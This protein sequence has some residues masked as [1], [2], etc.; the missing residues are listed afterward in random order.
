MT[1]EKQRRRFYLEVDDGFCI[2]TLLYKSK[3]W[4][5]EREWRLII[6][7]TK[8]LHDNDKGINGFLCIPDDAISEIILGHKVEN[9]IKE[10]AEHFCKSHNILLRKATINKTQYKIDIIDL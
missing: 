10:K 8:K 3:S 2:D 1:Y 9:H 5:Y 7:N 4:K 6:S